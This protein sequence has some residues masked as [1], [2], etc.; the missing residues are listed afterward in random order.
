MLKKLLVGAGLLTLVASPALAQARGEVTAT[1][2]WTFSDGVTFT[3]AAPV[4]GFIYDRAD[5]KDSVSFGLGGGFFI[6][7]QV[8]L[9]FMWN[10]QPTK[11]QVQGNGPVI[12]GDMNVDT[13][14]GNFVFHAGEADAKIRPF[15]YF[16]LGATNYGDASFPTRTITGT[17]K[18]SW[19]VGAGVKS[20]FS[21]HAGIRASVRWVPTYIKTDGYGWWCDPFWGC[22]PVGNTQYSNQFEL[23]GGVTFRF[24]PEPLEE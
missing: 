4:N 22:T 9:E 5:P 13:Y 23:S 20:Y 2:G 24:E 14:H 12:E 11:L 15:V 16:G 6:N 17:T 21:Q 3:N 10:R 8:E 18:F 7:H 1:V 19:A